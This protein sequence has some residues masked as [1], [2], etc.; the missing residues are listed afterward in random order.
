M[1]PQHHRRSVSAAMIAEAEHFVLGD[2]AILGH[3]HLHG[4]FVGT[5][6]EH[7]VLVGLERLVHDRFQTVKP[8]KGRLGAQGA[9]RKQFGHFA[10]V[11]QFNVLDSKLAFQRI[12]VNLAAGRQY[13]HVISLPGTDH[14]GFGHVHSGHMLLGSHLLGGERRAVLND[15]IFGGFLI[16]K[17]NHFHDTPL[18]NKLTHRVS[19][20]LDYIGTNSTG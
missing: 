17:I 8:A 1:T 14:N 2:S 20:L 9:V 13:A 12:K 3:I 4:L 15:L 16:Q 19:T 18:L 7:N 11:G 5:R 10:L 6:L